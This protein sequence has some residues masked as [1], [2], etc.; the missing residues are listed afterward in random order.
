MDTAIK[1]GQTTAPP[2]IAATTTPA[3]NSTMADTSEPARRRPNV[4]R[5][6]GFCN[7]NPIMAAISADARQPAVPATPASGDS[8]VSA[9]SGM[10][11]SRAKGASAA[12]S[13][14]R[15]MAAVDAG[16]LPISSGESSAETINQIRLPDT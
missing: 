9:A 12:Q 2:E 3:K 10:T 7:A 13:F 1:G 16:A 15:R 5:F 8:T 11:M 14:A 4:E 6:A